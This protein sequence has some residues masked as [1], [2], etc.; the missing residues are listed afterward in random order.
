MSGSEAIEAVWKNYQTTLDC[1]KIAQRGIAQDDASM[2]RSTGFYGREQDEAERR[3]AAIRKDAEDYII[4]SLWTAFE[5][6]L[7]AYLIE[8]SN[9]MLG[10][11]SGTFTSKVHQKIAGEVEY[12]HM[13]DALDLFKALVNA[14]QIG[15]AKK[16]KRYRDWVAHK[17]SNKPMPQAAIPEASYRLLLGISKQLEQHPDL[18]GN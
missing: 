7:F 6:S 2:T 11:A 10:A 13:E 15:E 1:L 18:R 4:V 14:N 9:R 3:I 8:Q 12:W 17:N 16:V 5:R